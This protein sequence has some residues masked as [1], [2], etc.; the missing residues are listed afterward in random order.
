[1]AS[2]TATVVTVPAGTRVLLDAN[3]D[4][5]HAATNQLVHA[6]VD[7][8]ADAPLKLSIVSVLASEDAAAITASLSLLP[9]DGCTIAA[10]SPAPTLDRGPRR[11]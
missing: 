2:S 11:R 6:I 4:G 9:D 8:D 10:R 5:E 7:V 1:M 3:L